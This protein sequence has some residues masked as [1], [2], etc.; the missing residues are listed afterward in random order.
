[1]GIGGHSGVIDAANSVGTILDEDGYKGMTHDIVKFHSSNKFDRKSMTCLRLTLTRKFS[2]LTELKRS[3]DGIKEFMREGC[4]RVHPRVGKTFNQNGSATTMGFLMDV[5]PQYMEDMEYVVAVRSNLSASELKSKKSCNVR[6][7]FDYERPIS[8]DF[9]L[10]N[11]INMWGSVNEAR[12]FIHAYLFGTWFKADLATAYRRYFDMLMN[13]YVGRVEWGDIGGMKSAKDVLEETFFVVEEHPDLFRDDIRD[14]VL[15][16]GPPGVGKTLLVKGMLNKLSGHANLVPFTAAAETFG[17]GEDEGSEALSRLFTFLNDISARTDSWTYLFIDEIDRLSMNPAS[18]AV[19][20][21]CMDND[22][23]R[24]FSIVATTNRPDVMDFALFRPGRFNPI[25]HVGLPDETDREGIWAVADRK[26]DFG[27]N[28]HTAELA[29]STGNFTG[30]DIMGISKLVYRRLR[31]NRKL[32][33]DYD[34][35]SDIMSIILKSRAETSKRNDICAGRV[36]EFT[37]SVDAN[38]MYI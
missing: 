12:I 1:M 33:N 36:R 16:V 29:T 31:L 20:L 2:G 34:P 37:S 25:I 32:G 5:F 28:G 4:M 35:C 26:Y 23:V 10:G 22:G 18:V 7:I 21:R 11:V 19:L 9:V 17:T 8:I 38:V 15:L 14:H 30:A 6:N 13:R 27:L 3:L 24:R